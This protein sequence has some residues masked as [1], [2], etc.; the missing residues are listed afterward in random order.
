MTTQPIEI[1]KSFTPEKYGYTDGNA[2]PYINKCIDLHG[3][4]FLGEKTYIIGRSDY[5]YWTPMGDYGSGSVWLN[6]NINWGWF[7][8]K[9]GVKLV[10]SGRDKTILKLA[11]DVMSTRYYGITRGGALL[12][13]TNYNE[14]CSDNIV[15]GIC[16]DGNYSNNSKSS[17]IQAIGINGNNN[18]V[19]NCKFIN[20]GVGDGKYAELFIIY[21][22]IW[23]RTK[24][25]NKIYNN[26]FTLTHAK[27]GSPAGFVP[28][29]TFACVVGN[30]SE[31]IGNV[32]ENC[33]FDVVNQQSPNH[34]INMGGCIGGKIIGNVFTNF[35]GACIY[36]DSWKNSNIEISGNIAKS[37][38][39]F[40]HLSCQAWPDASQISDTSN[41]EVH[42]NEIEL[43]DGLALYQWDKPGMLSCFVGVIYESSLSRVTYRGF[44]N[45]NVHDNKVTLGNNAGNLSYKLQC[46]W[47]WG[48]SIPESKIK[49]YN[50]R[51]ISKL[52]KP[53]SGLN[54]NNAIFLGPK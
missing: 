20:F 12:L 21:L 38:W 1:D 29:N 13:Q 8:K 52:I 30:N 31:V 42:N 16:F 25:G 11:D 47:P 41:Y 53:P 17:T 36:T 33:L 50:N 46:F 15:D 35:Q 10:G 23:D 3:S 48:E 49:L 28:E 40:L 51:F 22:G 6:N 37:C 14:T 19:Q 27:K 32:F 43:S 9:H 24:P 7:N 44:D 26:Y 54:W 4:C 34:A 39:T 5:N 45:I 2:A 18:T